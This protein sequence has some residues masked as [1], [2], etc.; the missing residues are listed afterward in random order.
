MLSSSNQTLQ[1]KT[2]R[3]YVN[4][5]PTKTSIWFGE[6]PLEPLFTKGHDPN[7]PLVNVYIAMERSTIYNR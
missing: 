7:Y 1:W 6:L 4:D 3:I 2:P 5:F